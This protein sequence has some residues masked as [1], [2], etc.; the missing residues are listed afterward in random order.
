MLFSLTHFLHILCNFVNQNDIRYPKYRFLLFHVEALFKAVIFSKV[1]SLKCQKKKI[2]IIFFLVHP[3]NFQKL[4]F[5]HQTLF[6]QI[7]TFEKLKQILA[8]FA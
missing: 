5:L 2:A 7:V 1:Q 4:Y 3:A 8:I 6:I